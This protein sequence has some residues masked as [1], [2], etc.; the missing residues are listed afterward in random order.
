M[1]KLPVRWGCALAFA[2]T[3]AFVAAIA[4]GF[5]LITGRA[6]RGADSVVW[7]LELA[8]I[9][10]P[11]VLLGLGGIRDRLAWAVALV[12]TAILWTWYLYDLS[13]GT[14]VNFL[15]G[16]IQVFVAPIS[17]SLLSFATAG[18]RGT[19]PDWDADE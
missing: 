12:L 6:L 13:R 14:G 8:I 4:V 7:L 19:I 3:S 10:P 18:M 1:P 17:I 15:L 11:F 9:G 5:S 2:I 16:F